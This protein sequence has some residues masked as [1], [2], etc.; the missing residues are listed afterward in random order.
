MDQE[1]SRNSHNSSLKYLNIKLCSSF[2]KTTTDSS[3]VWKYYGQIMTRNGKVIDDVHYYC[4]ECFLIEKGKVESS[5]AGHLSKIHKVRI[6]TSSSNLKNHLFIVHKI[7]TDKPA[8][9]VKNDQ[10]LRRWCSTSIASSSKY[11]LS[12]DLVLWFSTDLL[13]FSHVD[14]EGF[15]KFF[16]KNIGL[17]LP[18]GSAVSQVALPDMYKSLRRSVLGILQNIDAATILFDGWTDKYKK[19]NY[20][21]LKC[22][23]INENWHKKIFTLACLPLESHTGENCHNFIKDI[24][25]EFFQRRCRDIRLHTVH[26]GAANMMKTSRLLGSKDPQ[27]CLAHILHLILTCDGIDNCTETKCLLEKCRRIVTCLNFKSTLLLEESHCEADIKLYNNLRIL[28]EVKNID[29]LEQQFP[30]QIDDEANMIDTNNLD[31]S[32]NEKFDD[33][34]IK[35][36]HRSLKQ[37]IRTRWN[38]ALL[39]IESINQ[40]LDPVEIL[41]KKCGRQ[42]LCLD[43]DEQALISEL[44]KFLK[45]FESLTLVVSAGNSLSILPLVK[46]KIL[47]LLSINSC[48]LN[49]IKK[50]KEC[51]SRKIDKRFKLSTSAKICCFLDPATKI[52]YTRDEIKESLLEN[53]LNIKVNQLDLIQVISKSDN[54]EDSK[55]VPSA[56]RQLLQEIKKSVT[57]ADKNY[58]IDSEVEQFISHTPT[59]DEELDCLLF[60]RNHHAK[61]PH[62]AVLAKEYFSIPTSSVSVESMFS[63]TGLILNSRRSNLSSFNMN[64]TIFIHDNISLI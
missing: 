26:D 4:S 52:L 64:M 18:T 34:F 41:L 16:E 19:I 5:G 58:Q 9:E 8:A 59:T 22:S 32:C 14:N 25:Q 60:W 40:L 23:I 38:S 62:L 47:K 20:M 44:V 57:S 50:L 33:N 46:H 1:E 37:Q 35:R 39:M 21:G 63:L 51:C 2:K 7:L 3:L 49:E 56:K 10:L 36:Q 24:V 11:D 28:A 31:I 53:A 54:D 43:N 12:R 45:P 61:Y 55:S 42:D 48:D 17:K 13:P 6:S 30:I 15:K 29:D 27:H